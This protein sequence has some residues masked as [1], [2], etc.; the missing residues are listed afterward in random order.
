MSKARPVNLDLKTIRLPITAIVS[1]V[2]RVSS[3]ILWVSMAIFLPVL[4]LSLAS[5]NGFGDMLGFFDQN[6]LGK[7]VVW[8]LMTAFGY[9]FCATIKHII[10]DFGHCE[11]LDSGKSIS[12][13]VLVISGCFCV[14]SG[15][16]VW[17]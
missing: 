10:Q 16:W 14:L 9:Y 4:Y 15:V 12:I 13:A 3:V 6:P 8:G 11:E 2:H 1:I 17:A 5:E 7:F